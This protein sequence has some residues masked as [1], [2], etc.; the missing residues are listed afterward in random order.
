MGGEEL[1]GSLWKEA[2]EKAATFRR[3]AEGEAEAL[4]TVLSAR[5]EA[6]RTEFTGHPDSGGETGKI[7]LEAETRARKVRLTSVEGLSSRLYSLAVSCL[8][9]LREEGYD[10]VFSSLAR[11]LPPLEWQLVR[12]NPADEERAGKLFPYAEI[13]KDPGMSGGMEVE[14]RGGGLRVINTFEKRLEKSWPRLLP[15][16]LADIDRTVLTDGTPE[17]V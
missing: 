1:I 13:I 11:E 4:K 3:D 6:I 10:I 9:Y 8:P 7:L 17:K 5:F 12:V 16:L 14:A 15:G 2:H